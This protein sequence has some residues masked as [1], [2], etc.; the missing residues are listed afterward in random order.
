MINFDTTIMLQ[1]QLTAEFEPA[2]ESMGQESRV[3]SEARG[4][5]VRFT[6]SGSR[7]HQIRSTQAHVA[8]VRLWYTHW[9]PDE[10]PPF[11]QGTATVLLAIEG[12]EQPVSFP[13]GV[14]AA[15]CLASES[16]PNNI[17]L[18]HDF[19]V[20][21]VTQGSKVKLLERGAF[22]EA[23]SGADQQ[24]NEAWE[25]LCGTVQTVRAIARGV[26]SLPPDDDELEQWEFFPQL[27]ELYFDDNEDWKGFSVDMPWEMIVP[28]AL[29]IIPALLY[30]MG[31]WFYIYSSIPANC[32]I[33]L[34]RIDNYTGSRSDWTWIDGTSH[35]HDDFEW[36]SEKDG[37][38]SK[39]RV[40]A[41]VVQ[42]WSRY[43]SLGH[44][45]LS[46]SYT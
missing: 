4:G 33:G 3:P 34:E 31:I 12:F 17:L 28:R 27:E 25:P 38:E 45:P 6:E 30:L 37:S 9:D 44:P 1:S 42:G 5:G 11:L 29:I 26:K 15:V 16:D 18:Q 14:V 10:R 23:L 40:A 7:D 35:R 13:F 36:A 8:E 24:W 41:L 19:E 21:V 32:F 43:H 2:G 20:A 39:S 46:N 22:E